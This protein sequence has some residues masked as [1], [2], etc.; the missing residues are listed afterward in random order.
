MI[1]IQ[2]EKDNLEKKLFAK[3]GE[4]FEC[5]QVP[6]THMQYKFNKYVKYCSN[7]DNC[8]CDN[9]GENVYIPTYIKDFES[10]FVKII[11]TK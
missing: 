5:I 4:W 9:S 8:I 3:K 2:E 11:L 7:S 10:H 1:M 6:K